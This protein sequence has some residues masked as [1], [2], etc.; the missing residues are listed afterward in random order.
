VASELAKKHPKLLVLQVEAE[1]QEE[2]TDSFTIESVP[3]FL[4]LRGHNLLARIDGADAAKLTAAAAEHLAPTAPAAKSTTDKA[5]PAPGRL[6]TE[7]PEQLTARMQALMNQ[8]SVVLFMKG[9]PD[10]PRCGF[11]RSTVALLREKGVE[12]SHF[13]ILTDED[14]RQGLKKHN[15]WP[16]FPQII[17]NGEFVGGLD[18]LREMAESP[19]WDDIFPKKTG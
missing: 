17:V 12:F 7:T 3:T 6:G 2:I 13:D 11:S 19:E 8:S 1:A 10:T 14:V 15:D 4:L 5:P 9:S 18:V 16:T